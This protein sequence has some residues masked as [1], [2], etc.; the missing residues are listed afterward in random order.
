M[1]RRIRQR[2]ETR[3]ES[4]LGAWPRDL[5]LLLFSRPPKASKTDWDFRWRRKGAWLRPV[6][7]FFSSVFLHVSAFLLA[8]QFAFMPVREAPRQAEDQD[9]G[10]IYIDMAALKILRDLPR[11]KPAGR[12]GRPG[13][14]R[15][16]DRVPAPGT[17][18]F[19]RQYTIVLNPMKPDNARQAVVQKSTAP[20]MVIPTDQKLPDIILVK[21]PDIATQVDLTFH[22]PSVSQLAQNQPAAQAPAI[23]ANAPQLPIRIAAT[24]QQPQLPVSYLNSNMTPLAR[25]K[26]SAGEQPNAAAPSI[27][28]S[29][30]QL[31]IRIAN[32]GQQ[33][34]LPGST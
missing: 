20:D 2:F 19:H 11:V 26:N 34:Q 24:V 10:P 8:I 1:V 25:S 4:R 17:T 27:A 29:A 32:A 13:V 14:A 16:P 28:S 3:W 5:A 6:G 30:P 23:P 22:R 12:G 9:T 31:S 18:V 33:P 7:G 15:Q 21:Q